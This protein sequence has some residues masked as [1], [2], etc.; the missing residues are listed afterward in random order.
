M[1]QETKHKTAE[2]ISR[3]IFFK[4]AT[5]GQSEVSISEG[6]GLIR[7]FADQE[8]EKEKQR[9]KKLVEALEKIAEEAKAWR[10]KGSYRVATAARA[11][12]RAASPSRTDKPEKE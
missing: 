8:V 11:E 10:G 5:N 7:A 6:A 1:T 2:E 12:Y 3:I 9:S 4:P